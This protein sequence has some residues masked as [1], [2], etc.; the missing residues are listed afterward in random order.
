MNLAAINLQHLRA[1]RANRTEMG[2]SPA[3]DSSV[4]MQPRSLAE[5][6]LPEALLI[7]LV[8]KHLVQAR[9]STLAELA[10]RIA[11]A[12]T[13]LEPLLTSLRERRLIDISQRGMVDAQMGFRLTDTGR[14]R[15]AEAMA[16]SRYCGA[17][18][19]SLDQY[20]RCIER[21]AI[22]RADVDGTDL[23]DALS[24]LAVTDGLFED[25]G[26][27]LNS[28]RSIYLYGPSGSGKT[29]LA[30]RLIG[31]LPGTVRVPH[32]LW[33]GDQV[34]TVFDPSIHRMAPRA[35]DAASGLD[36][37]ARPDGR[38]V[39]VHRPVVVTGGELTLEALDLAFDPVTRIHAAPPQL[40][41]NGGLLIVDD[42]G[43]QRVSPRALINRWIVPLD[44][45]VDFLALTH[46]TRIEVPFDVRVVFASNLAPADLAD[47]AFVRRIGYKV[48]IGAMPEPSYRALVRSACDRHGISIDDA[49]IDHLVRNL[50]VRHGQP[51]LP[52]IPFDLVDKLRDR[53][54]YLGLPVRVSR[55][56]LDWAWRLYFGT[57]PGPAK[58]EGAHG[59]ESKS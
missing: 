31:A 48:H 12:G 3:D 53:A 50:H 9:E 43:R 27:A 46:G 5:L 23:R 36:R 4:P 44:R 54:G 32:A 2:G 6:D 14:Q 52:A 1:V 39:E 38:W 33:A 45:R 25:L 10:G 37:A 29:S 40:K 57:G 7:D 21:Q 15:A 22:D 30:E 13:I 35:V 18:P 55:E 19:V 26:S 56:Q 49:M 47:P 24:D 11:L 28:G 58:P 16:A 51:L 41:A 8:L 34:I 20:R 59:A 17:A 42:L